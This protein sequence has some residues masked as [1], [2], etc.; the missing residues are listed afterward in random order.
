MHCRS[1]GILSRH[2]HELHGNQARFNRL[3]ISIMREAMC[4]SLRG[5]VADVLP[6][7]SSKV[8]SYPARLRRDI[9][10][11]HTAANAGK[12]HGPRGKASI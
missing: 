11:L 8:S 9:P 10:G 5:Q 4:G 2:V 3:R 7:A 1:L 12:E 6:R